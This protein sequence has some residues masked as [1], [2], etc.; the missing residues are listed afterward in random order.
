MTAPRFDRDH[1]S[2][3]PDG[4]APAA[5]RTDARTEAPVAAN[6][7]AADAPAQEE[8]HDEKMIDEPGYGHGV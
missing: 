7:R 6:A 4:N 1:R 8:P 5:A 2:G 3:P